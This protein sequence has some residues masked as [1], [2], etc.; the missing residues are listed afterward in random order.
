[1]GRFRV[2]DHEEG[3]FHLNFPLLLSRR[4]LFENQWMESFLI[5]GFEMHGDFCIQ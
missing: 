1:M 4:I 2:P 5:A 3:G